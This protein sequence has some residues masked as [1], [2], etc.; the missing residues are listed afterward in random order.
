MSDPYLL[1]AIL[2]LQRSSVDVALFVH[3]LSKMKLVDVQKIHLSEKV[4]HIPNQTS[5][6][7]SYFLQARILQTPSPPTQNLKQLAS[8]AMNPASTFS[9]HHPAASIPKHN[10]NLQHYRI[11]AADYSFLHEIFSELSDS[12]SEAEIRD[13]AYGCVGTLLTRNGLLSSYGECGD[14]L[15]YFQKSKPLSNLRLE[16]EDQVRS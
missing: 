13:A 8:L 1:N 5:S 6:P 12:A 4:L 3:S 11:W 2:A 10:E 14:V 16:Y 9:H 7:P 15:I